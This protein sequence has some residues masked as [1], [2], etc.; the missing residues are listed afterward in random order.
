MSFDDRDDPFDDLFDE[1]NRMMNSMAGSNDA[2]FGADT[3]V[4]VYADDELVRLVADLPGIDK[5]DLNLQCDGETLTIRAA[6]EGREYTERVRLPARVDE[7]SADATFNNGI[8]E[9]SFDRIEDSAA[10]DVE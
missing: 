1:I 4:D 9:I 3:H 10:I 2:G 7:H 5:D 6:G 8:L